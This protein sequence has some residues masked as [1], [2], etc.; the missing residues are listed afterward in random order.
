MHIGLVGPYGKHLGELCGSHHK[1]NSGQ[2][3]GMG[4]LAQRGVLVSPM[5]QPVL[6]PWHVCL[7]PE[8]WVFPAALAVYSLTLGFQVVPDGAQ[9]S[10]VF[11][12]LSCVRQAT[13]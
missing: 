10:S 7:A 2:T 8:P 3:L 5:R 4:L 6:P 12:S 13:V 11:S 1:A 9:Q